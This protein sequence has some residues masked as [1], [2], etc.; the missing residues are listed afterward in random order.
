MVT[1]PD[2]IEPDLLGELRHRDEIGNAISY[3][4]SGSWIP[5]FMGRTLL[6]VPGA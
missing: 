2:R 4:T 5:T 3:S 6:L 1:Q